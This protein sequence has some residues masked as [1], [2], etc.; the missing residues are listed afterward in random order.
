[1]TSIPNQLPQLDLAVMTS[2]HPVAEWIV[3]KSTVNDAVDIRVGGNF[4][5]ER[6]QQHVNRLL[7]IAGGVGIN[8]LYSMMQQWFLDVAKRD[9]ASRAV[10]LYSAATMHDFL[11][12]NQLKKMV[13]A[14]PD[15]LSIVLTTT[16]RD[17]SI[18]LAE[19]DAKFVTNNLML[20]SGRIDRSMVHDA[21]DWLQRTQ[22][23][24]HNTVADSVFICGPPGMP[25]SLKEILSDQNTISKGF[26]KSEADIYFEKWW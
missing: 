7:F 13:D 26:V 2:R 19:D 16:K 9:D 12:V 11:F 5:Y 14:I 3:E 25:E 18:S 10:L 24:E 1:M 17:N 20:K 15:R 6:E 8:P 22:Q 4:T 21:V 23:D